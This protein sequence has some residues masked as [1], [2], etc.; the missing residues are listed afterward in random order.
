LTSASHLS[1]A[2]LRGSLSRGDA[3]EYSDIDIAWEVPG[4]EF[5]GS[6]GRLA[7]ILSLAGRVESL[8]WDPDFRGA[9]GRRV[10]FVRFAMVPLF[11]RVDIDIRAG[12]QGEPGDV[13]QDR[14]E[15]SPAESALMNAVAAIKAVVRGD[16][17]AA[18]PLLERG[19]A[20]LD[21]PAP[22][23]DTRTAVGKLLDFA[24]SRD[25]RQAV[26]AQ[27]IRDELVP[28]LPVADATEH[29]A[30]EPV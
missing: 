3:D 12:G 29:K 22:M 25:N 6:V 28:N 1:R 11:W 17:A 26:L 19:F 9:R 23:G 18:G 24:V 21:A 8:R 20:R 2:G 30:D 15:W 4:R 16:R 13:E 5:T 7:E 14:Q 27:R 10:A